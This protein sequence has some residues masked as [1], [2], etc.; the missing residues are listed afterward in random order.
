[1]ENNT[2]IVK[3]HAALER[4]AEVTPPLY[5][6][7]ESVVLAN[8]LCKDKTGRVAAVLAT[9]ALPVIGACAVGR[10]IKEW[11]SWKVSTLKRKR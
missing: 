1:M 5:G 2:N 7:P 3:R 9:A 10:A 6:A 4:Y 11:T 8:N